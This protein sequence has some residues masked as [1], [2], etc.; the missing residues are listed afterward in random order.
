VGGG[1]GGGRW[2]GALGDVWKYR[3]SLGS[4]FAL[5]KGSK[6]TK[7]STGKVQ[8]PKW[9][10]RGAKKNQSKKHHKKKKPDQNSRHGESAQGKVEKGGGANCS[11]SE[12]REKSKADTEQRHRVKKTRIW[13][14]NKEKKRE[15]I[16]RLRLKKLHQKGKR[17]SK[18][19]I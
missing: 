16:L 7:P 1:W 9:G 15:Q 2:G 6:E 13:F 4:Y 14:G 10:R 8:L 19:C 11:R 3:E 17:G 18:C 12:G 5:K